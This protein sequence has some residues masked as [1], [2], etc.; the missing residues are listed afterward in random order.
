MIKIQNI[1]DMDDT[2]L[3]VI[4]DKSVLDHLRC[5]CNDYLVFLQ[6]NFN[7]RYFIMIKSDNGYK[8]KRYS[9]M[10]KTY[11]INIRYKYDIVPEFDHKECSYFLKDN[12]TIRVIIK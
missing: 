8:I 9:S 2:L 1:I 4:F 6:S 12:S 7:K 10:R 11:Q 5:K 3:T